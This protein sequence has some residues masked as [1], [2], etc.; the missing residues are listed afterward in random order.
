MP[1]AELAALGPGAAHGGGASRPRGCT[2]A[3]VHPGGGSVP[4]GAARGD[5]TP[6]GTAPPPPFSATVLCSLH[7]SQQ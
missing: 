5:V 2:D 1:E 7:F 4:G 3:G 6:L